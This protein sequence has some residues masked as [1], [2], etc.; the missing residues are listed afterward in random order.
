MIH[1]NFFQCYYV[2]YISS[3]ISH[4]FLVTPC[5][6]IANIEET[7]DLDNYPFNIKKKTIRNQ[8]TEVTAGYLMLLWWRRHPVDRKNVVSRTFHPFSLFTILITKEYTNIVTVSDC[9]R[10]PHFVLHIHLCCI[11]LHSEQNKRTVEVFYE[12]NTVSVFTSLNPMTRWHLICPF[13]VQL[14]FLFGRAQQLSSN[15]HS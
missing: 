4:H 12:L 10:N 3:I 11:H 14:M 5:Y 13:A 8:W 9:C 2:T 6:K 15:H 7:D 1:T